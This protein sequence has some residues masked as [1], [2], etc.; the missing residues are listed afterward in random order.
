MPAGKSPNN[1]FILHKEQMVD[2]LSDIRLDQKPNLSIQPSLFTN[3]IE[4]NL[5]RPYFY[6]RY[7]SN[8]N[9]RILY[10]KGYVN[11]Q[12]QVVGDKATFFLSSE[13]GSLDSINNARQYY[14][15]GVRAIGAME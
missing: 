6:W 13:D 5:A 8:Q 12:G 11:R 10:S 14:T 7:N 4:N 3:T 9:C 2:V 15:D 1:A